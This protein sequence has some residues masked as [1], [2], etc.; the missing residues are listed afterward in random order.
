MAL[1]I[2]DLDNT[3]IAGDSDHL[4]GEFLC[5]RGVVDA[6][7]FRTTNQ[8]F[9]ED[10]Q[11]GELD[12][13]AYAAFALGPLAGK[14]PE[15]VVGLQQ[16]FMA[17]CIEALMLPA[18][19][20]LIEQHRDR[21]D[22]LLIITATNEFVTRPIG[23]RLGI[24][25]LLGCAV[26]MSDGRFTGRATGTLT[27]REGKVARLREWLEDEEE[28]LAG[29]TFYSDSH[30]DLPLLEIVDYPVLV[31]PDEKLAAVGRERDWPRLSLRQGATPLP[32]E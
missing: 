6:E 16:D 17:S 23:E 15:S 1:A 27:Y 14:T 2:F 13:A 26:E 9:Y 31:D 29:A 7:H 5:D 24:E 21:G 18:A 20:A 4:W 25:E 12:I 30:N 22:R 19:E 8:A 10:Y 3:L 11:R 28:E 32:L